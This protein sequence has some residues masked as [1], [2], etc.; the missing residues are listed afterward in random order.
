MTRPPTGG[1]RPLRLL[2]ALLVAA[3]AASEESAAAPDPPPEWHVPRLTLAG[4]AADRPLPP[5]E[6]PPPPPE[7]PPAR[8]GPPYPIVLAHGFFGFEDFAGAD[9]ASYFYR[10]RERLLEEGETEVFT[11]AVDPFNDSTHRGA[12]LL[13]HV[14]AIV[15]TTGRDKV[16]IVAHSQGGLDAR[17]VASV[18]PDL[19]AAVVTISTPHRGT[20]IAAD[21]LRAVDR[22][23]LRPIVDAVGQIF[24]RPL[25][26]AADADTSL[27]AALRQLGPEGARRFTE[28]YPDGEGVRYYSLAGRS[29]G[30]L[31]DEDCLADGPTPA[32]VRRWS[33]ERDPIDPLFTLTEA[34][35]DGDGH[36]RNDGMVRVRDARYGRFLG[37]IPADHMDEVGQVLGDR[38]GGDNRFDHLAFYVDLVHWLRAHGL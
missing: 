4:R 38:P 22:R 3:C 26:E 34:I 7:E 9:F 20:P 15:R 11:P 36:V 31:D 19:V 25:Y 10:V 32:F 35:L 33:S 30:L 29:D 37:C 21:V 28:R 24:G 2:P 17:Y 14:E 23:L 16:V 13:A 18:R 27:I 12:Q 6:V 1:P 8:L 5:P